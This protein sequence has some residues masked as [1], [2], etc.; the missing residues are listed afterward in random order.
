MD[1]KKRRSDVEN[2]LY[3]KGKTFIKECLQFCSDS[4]IDPETIA[5]AYIE[6]FCFGDDGSLK[7][8]EIHI[9]A[10]KPTES[11]QEHCEEGKGAPTVDARDKETACKKRVEIFSVSQD[12]MEQVEALRFIWGILIEAE[13][14]SDIDDRDCIRIAAL[15]GNCLDAIDKGAQELHDLAYHESLTIGGVELLAAELKHQEHT[16]ISLEQ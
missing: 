15:M 9:A 6:D 7:D 5:F 11:M 14:G 4:N 12:I 16:D 13:N 8:L 2:V 10:P 1:E 3:N